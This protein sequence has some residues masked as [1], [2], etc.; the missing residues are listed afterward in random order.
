MFAIEKRRRAAIAEG[1]WNR[2][3]PRRTGIREG[4]LSIAIR[5]ECQ[6]KVRYFGERRR[7]QKK[8]DGITWRSRAALKERRYLFED[9]V[10]AK[11]R[12]RLCA[13][14]CSLGWFQFRD[15]LDP[16]IQPPR[17]AVYS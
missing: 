15:P 9:A 8:G 5:L 6:R 4:R 17:I 2:Q 10:R 1:I 11:A 3:I 16:K 13:R 12:P 14:V 7:R